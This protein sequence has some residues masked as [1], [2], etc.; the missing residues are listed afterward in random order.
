MNRVFQNYLDAFLV[1]FIDY[2]FVYSKRE[3]EHMGNLSLVLHVLKEQQLFHKF[4]K[5]EFFLRS[6]AILG[7]IISRGRSKENGSDYELA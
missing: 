6:V 1:V 2:I 5:C 4:S 7:H 3:E